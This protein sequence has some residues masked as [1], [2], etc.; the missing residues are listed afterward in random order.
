MTMKERKEY[1]KRKIYEIG[2]CQSVRSRSQDDYEDFMKLFTHHP[3]Y[4]KKVSGVVDIKIVPN[5]LTPRFYELNIVKADGSI[6]NISYTC[7]CVLKHNTFKNLK[8][9]MREFIIPQILDYKD[10]V[11]MVCQMCGA[12]DNIEIDHVIEFK[13]L[14][15]AFIGENPNV[16]T[17]FDETYYHAPCFKEADKDFSNSW[18]KYHKKH[19]TLRPLCKSC[20]LNR[21]RK[22]T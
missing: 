20:N 12:T 7:C 21:N 8:Q 15:D 14:F 2:L 10:S 3:D 1:Y 18:Y 16:P 6:D 19:A 5:K 17:S 11:I 13:K 22:A 9:A 4:P